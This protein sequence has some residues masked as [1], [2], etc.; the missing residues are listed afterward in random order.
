MQYSLPSLLSLMTFAVETKSVNPPV[1]L[2]TFD[3]G[4]SNWIVYFL[5]FSPGILV[6]N[7]VFRPYLLELRSL[8]SNLAS[9]LAEILP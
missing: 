3:R 9:V 6:D 4:P 1:L 5:L 7:E 8:L 2:R